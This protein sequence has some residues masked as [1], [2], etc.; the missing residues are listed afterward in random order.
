MP[1]LASVGSVI[2]GSLAAILISSK[3]EPLGA[4]LS[5]LDGTNHGGKFLCEQSQ[6]AVGAVTRHRQEDLSPEKR[7]ADNTVGRRPADVEMTTIPLQA[8]AAATATTATTVVAVRDGG[9]SSLDLVG[10]GDRVL[11]AM[12]LAISLLF[13]Y[14]SSLVGSSDLLGCFLGGLAFSG[15]PGVQRVWA[16]Q[17]NALIG[18][19]WFVVQPAFCALKRRGSS[20]GVGLDPSAPTVRLPTHALA[21]HKPKIEVGAIG[22]LPFSVPCFL[23][24]FLLLVLCFFSY[25]RSP[26]ANPPPQIYS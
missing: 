23:P 10:R 9:D 18:V 3:T 20:K 14:L 26:T 4:W 15:V 21:L 12:V 16:R 5:S 2:V 7:L 11:L 24:S 13:A 25:R 6:T 17:V 8:G 19:R 1:I 22:S